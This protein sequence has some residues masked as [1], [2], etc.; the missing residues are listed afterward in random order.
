VPFLRQACRPGNGH[1][2]GWI[3]R[4]TADQAASDYDERQNGRAPGRPRRLP[5]IDFGAIGRLLLT[6]RTD[7]ST[8]HAARQGEDYCQRKRRMDRPKPPTIQAARIAQLAQTA[9]P[10]LRAVSPAMVMHQ[11][12][13]ASRTDTST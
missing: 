1:H 10:R 12:Q 3:F 5:L 6:R 9:R 4:V 8:D 11:A 7:D 13:I 2:Y